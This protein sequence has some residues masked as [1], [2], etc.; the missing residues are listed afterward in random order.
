MSVRIRVSYEHEPELWDVLTGLGSRVAKI[1]YAPASGR[2][3]RAYI[4]V[5]PPPETPNKRLTNRPERDTI[6]PAK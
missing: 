6:T 5:K 4:E 3:R 1:K 2:F